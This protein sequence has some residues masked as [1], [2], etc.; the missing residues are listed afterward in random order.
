MSGGV[1]YACFFRRR[2]VCC[3]FCAVLLR[4]LCSS[5]EMLDQPETTSKN[6]RIFEPVYADPGFDLHQEMC[7]RSLELLVAVVGTTLF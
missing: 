2:S 5:T 6:R 1:A 7:L 4:V 3:M